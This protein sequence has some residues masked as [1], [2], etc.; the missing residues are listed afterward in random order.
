[1]TDL[2]ELHW[3]RGA[4][5]FAT[6]QVRSLCTT[7]CRLPSSNQSYSSPRISQYVLTKD[8]TPPDYGTAEIADHALALSL[9][10]RRGVLLHH[11]RQ[12]QPYVDSWMYIDTPLV[13]RVHNATF[14]ILGLGRIGT[15]AC[16]RAKAFG[17][18]VLFYGK[19]IL[20]SYRAR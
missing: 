8:G 15:A 18:N 10:L 2:I 5:Q 9:A 3:P 11:D 4:S 12:R 17:W 13:S 1:M 20:T 19:S 14:G 16:L 7:L 6:Y